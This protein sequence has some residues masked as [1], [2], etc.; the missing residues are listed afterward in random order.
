[1]SYVNVSLA[2]QRHLYQI[3]QRLNGIWFLTNTIK[4]TLSSSSLFPFTLTVFIPLPA[5]I[6]SSTFSDSLLHFLVNSNSLW[7]YLAFISPL[8]FFLWDQILLYLFLA[9]FIV[10]AFMY[11]LFWVCKEKLFY[12]YPY[13][14]NVFSLMYLYSMSH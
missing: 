9:L 4:Q 7:R 5:T 14:P 3:L 8:L 1:M 12:F 11:F 2:E 10:T 13:L 6:H